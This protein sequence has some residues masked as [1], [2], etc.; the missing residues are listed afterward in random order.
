MENIMLTRKNLIPSQFNNQLKYEFP[1]QTQFPKGTRISLEGY[2]I[3]NSFFNIEKKRGNNKISIFCDRN[4]T[5]YE[6]TIDDG[7][8]TISE[9]NGLLQYFCILENLFVYDTNGNKVFFIEIK[10]NPTAY[11]CEIRCLQ[12]PTIQEAVD[13][14]YTLPIGAS[15]ALHVSDNYISQIEILSS[16]FGGLIGF[17]VGI[18]PPTVF[19]T[20]NYSQKSQSSPSINIVS[21]MTFLCSAVIGDYS[22]PPNVIKFKSLVKGYGDLMEVDSYKDESKLLTI[23][24]LKTFTITI[25]DQNH[26]HFKLNDKDITLNIGLHVPIPKETIN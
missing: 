4:S 3:H 24:N 11:A 13:L 1:T 22:N 21:G 26:E 19:E 20:E 23:T 2:S 25:L 9:I 6:F 14:E 5:N 7:F 15:W 18:Y 16:T 17:D 8:Y 12:I 10:I